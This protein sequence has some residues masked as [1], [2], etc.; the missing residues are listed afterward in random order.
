MTDE[1]K[2]QG[3]SEEQGIRFMQALAR[4][5]ARRDLVSGRNFLLDQQ[6]AHSLNVDAVEDAKAA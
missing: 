5:C 6:E 2:F 3:F 4:Q 1:P